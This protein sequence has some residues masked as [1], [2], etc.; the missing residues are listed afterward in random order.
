MQFFLQTFPSLHTGVHEEFS[1]CNSSNVPGL[2]RTVYIGNE[3]D[4]LFIDMGL[5]NHGTFTL[6]RFIL[7]MS[8]GK[9]MNC[10]DRF[11]I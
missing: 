11:C 6:F 4:V 10:D 3:Q 2:G 9:L 7:H 8:P 5:L 1:H